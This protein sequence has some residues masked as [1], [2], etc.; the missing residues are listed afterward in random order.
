[1]SPQLAMTI[2]SAIEA[3]LWILAGLLFW[4]KKLQCCFPAMGA[5]LAL[6]LVATPVFTGLVYANLFAHE[7][8][9]R[10]IYFFLYWA[11]YLTSAILWFFICREIFRSVATD[12]PALMRL[13][14]VPLRW[15]AL[16]LV[17][18]NVSSISYA[19]LGYSSL[20]FVAMRLM[21]SA[22]I[23]TLCLLAFVFLSM[24]ALHISFRD[25]SF[26]IVL[27]MAVL[28]A[29]DFIQSL[30]TS[31]STTLTDTSQFV[32]EAVLLLGM[33]IWVVYFA[34]AQ[35]VGKHLDA[36]VEMTIQV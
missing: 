33:C 24:K 19:H 12:H 11:V 34:R 5:Y 26:G 1:M 7:R 20:P 16:V 9:F 21:R 27:G 32:Y 36:S 25:I 22:S 3:A 6:H 2:L 15:M 18:L 23:V 31:I 10:T 29:A 14:G 28:S 35:R 17:I 8:I 30:L 4:R 13:S